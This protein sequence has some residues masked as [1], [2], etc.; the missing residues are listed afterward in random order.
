MNQ[1]ANQ[2]V[3]QRQENRSIFSQHEDDERGPCRCIEAWGE[4]TGRLASIAGEMGFAL[5]V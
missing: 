3:S 2:K 5:A 4:H 1:V